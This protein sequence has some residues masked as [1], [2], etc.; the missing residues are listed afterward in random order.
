MIAQI[1]Q[2][3]SYNIIQQITIYFK[4]SQNDNQTISNLKY[5]FE[6]KYR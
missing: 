5:W 6:I 3:L 4:I 1:Y 2:F